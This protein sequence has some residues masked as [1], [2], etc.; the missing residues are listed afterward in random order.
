M[1][2]SPGRKD[3]FV[4]ARR[5]LF[6]ESKET[7]V[8]A[9]HSNVPFRPVHQPVGSM[10]RLFLC[11]L[12]LG[13]L[14]ND[15]RAQEAD[16]ADV[17]SIDAI[18]AAYYEVVSGPAGAIPDYERDKSLHHPDAWIA[19]ANV[20]E[21]G[22]PLVRTMTLEGFYGELGPRAENFYEWEVERSTQRHG[23]MV[24]VWSRYASAREPDGE[25]YTGG[26]NSITL[27]HDG[28]RWWIMGWMFDRS[29]E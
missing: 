29:G 26:V 27:W 21:D 11:I 2:A 9:G 28:S 17:S 23:N 3:P 6:Q 18:I 25:P 7:D 22:Q 4:Y 1:D 8:K 15:T 10:Y 13:I 12:A 5:A 19:I 20:D 14:A 24:H 16:P